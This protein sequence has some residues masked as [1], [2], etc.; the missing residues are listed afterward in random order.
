MAIST[1]ARIE[2]GLVA[3]LL[4]TNGPID[5]LFHPSLTW[6]KCSSSVK[7]GWSFSGGVFAAPA[8]AAPPTL[9][10]IQAGIVAGIQYRLDAWA[11]TRLYDGILSA[12]TYATSTVPRFAAEG[13]AAVEA[14]DV[15]WAATYQLLAEVEAGTRTMV[16]SYEEIEPLLPTL[17]WPQ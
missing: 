4:K 5:G 14:R 8:P 1:Y 6:V 3:E 17:E 12:C 7:E 13:Q 10:Q 15:T 9:E 11:R 2:G 16:S